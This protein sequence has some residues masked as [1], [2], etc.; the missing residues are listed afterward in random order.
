MASDDKQVSD[1]DQFLVGDRVAILANDPA[2]DVVPWPAPADF[3]Q[4]STANAR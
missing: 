1:P 4:F 3:D 2:E